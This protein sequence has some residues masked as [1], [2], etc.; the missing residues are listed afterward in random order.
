[1]NYQEAVDVLVKHKADIRFNQIIAD[2]ALYD[3]ESRLLEAIDKVCGIVTTDAAP[4]QDLEPDMNAIELHQFLNKI[5][6][7]G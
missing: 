6:E 4:V 3:D 1:M 5:C 2:R 7:R